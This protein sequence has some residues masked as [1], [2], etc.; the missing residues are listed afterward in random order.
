MPLTQAQKD[1][2]KKWDKENMTVVACRLTK[3]KA[4]LFKEAC[5]EIGLSPNRVLLNTVDQTIKEAEK[6]KSQE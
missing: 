4:A 3:K 2:R 1:A 5:H 6:M